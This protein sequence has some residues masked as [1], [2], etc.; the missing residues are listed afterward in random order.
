M[1]YLVLLGAAVVVL[2]IVGALVGYRRLPSEDQSLEDRLR[3][4]A[5]VTLKTGG[6]FTGVLYEYDAKALVLRN[7]QA[8]GDPPAP[9]VAV[10]GELLVLWAEVA[11]MQLT[12]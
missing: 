7:A 3:R 4:Q 10:D 1:A 6:S 5:V 8:I 9:H 12:D 11:Y 2:L